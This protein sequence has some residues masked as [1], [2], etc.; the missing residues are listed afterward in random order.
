MGDRRYGECSLYP[1]PCLV[2]AAKAEGRDFLADGQTVPAQQLGHAGAE[3]AGADKVQPVAAPA[4]KAT[5]CV[6]SS[7]VTT[8]VRQGDDH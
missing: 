1:S 2:A 6:N 7:I 8:T 4:G 3:A 5:F